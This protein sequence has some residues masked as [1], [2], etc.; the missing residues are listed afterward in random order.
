MSLLENIQTICKNHGISVPKLEKEIGL[1][2]GAIYKWSISSPTA[3]KLQKVADYF[4]VSTDYLLGRADPVTPVDEPEIFAIQRA[5][6]NMSPVDKK[7]MLKLIKLSFE[8][9][10]SEDE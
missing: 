2:N 9:A 3:D 10:F 8:E 1:G 4:N 5:A 7:K 6:K